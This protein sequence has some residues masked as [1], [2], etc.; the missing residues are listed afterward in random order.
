LAKLEAVERAGGVLVYGR[1]YPAEIRALLL[2]APA[3]LSRNEADTLHRYRYEH[4]AGYREARD[5]VVPI[6]ALELMLEV[7]ARRDFRTSPG[8]EDMPATVARELL[9]RDDASQAAK[10]QAQ[11]YL[12]DYEA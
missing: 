12:R 4:D 1:R 2:K 11:R 7:I 3:H 10:Q 5:R 6:R 8:Y 9:S